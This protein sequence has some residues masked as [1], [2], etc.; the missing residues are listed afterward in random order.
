[1]KNSTRTVQTVAVKLVA[2]QYWVGNLG[3]IKMSKTIV[4]SGGFCLE[5]ESKIAIK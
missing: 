4:V 2:Q 5:Y 1:M 3:T